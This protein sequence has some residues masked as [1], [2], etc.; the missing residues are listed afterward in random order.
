MKLWKFLLLNIAVIATASYVSHECGESHG[1][2]KVETVRE[3]V[4]LDRDF[5][6]LSVAELF[7]REIR[8]GVEFNAHEDDCDKIQEHTP[9]RWEKQ[10]RYVCRVWGPWA[11]V[12]AVEAGYGKK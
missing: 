11:N 10:T 8:A 1:E 7:Q 3:E 12:D 2:T 5:H 9:G 6:V 4:C